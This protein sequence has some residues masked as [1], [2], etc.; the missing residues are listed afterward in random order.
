VKQTLVSSPTST[1]PG[2]GTLLIIDDED[3][4]RDSTARLLERS[5]YRILTAAN[6]ERG[7]ALFEE[8][9]AK[10][11]LV[12]LDLSMPTMSGHEVLVRLRRMQPSVRVMILTGY[13]IGDVDFDAAVLRK[14]FTIAELES[15]I[16]EVLR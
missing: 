4:V 15:M 5:G 16:T 12:L 6:G 9:G 1:D 7:L 11:D 14:P 3:L 13:A 8:H 2:L 10:I